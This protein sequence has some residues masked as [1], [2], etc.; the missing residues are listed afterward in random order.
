MFHLFSIIISCR[1]NSIINK[2][3]RDV[4]SFEFNTKTEKLQLAQDSERNSTDCLHSYQYNLRG[5]E[6][7]LSINRKH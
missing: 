4:N 2:L 7:C 5:K 3:I 6:H 1:S